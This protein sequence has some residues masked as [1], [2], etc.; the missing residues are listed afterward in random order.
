MRIKIGM[1]M[2]V[3]VSILLGTPL[4]NTLIKNIFPFEKEDSPFRLISCSDSCIVET[5]SR[6][7]K[8]YS[9]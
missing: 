7:D 3:A 2:K 6:Q 8:K 1:V 4:I 9:D 5:G